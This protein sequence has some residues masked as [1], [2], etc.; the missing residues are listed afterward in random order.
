MIPPAMKSI[1][2][3]LCSSLC[4][5]NAIRPGGDVAYALSHCKQTTRSLPHVYAPLSI[6]VGAWSGA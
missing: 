4:Q 5:Q 3:K 6:R 1:I 2:A